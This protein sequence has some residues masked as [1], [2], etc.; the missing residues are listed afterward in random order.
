MQDT[1][2][3]ADENPLEDPLDPG[4][5]GADLANAEDAA[6]TEII[7]EE[8]VE[9]WEP[10]PSGNGDCAEMAVAEG[11]WHAFE[12]DSIRQGG[13]ACSVDYDRSVMG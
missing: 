4:L 6:D 13:F 8:S 11:G 7:E 1:E 10:T 5:P 3:A 12:C 2:P 9:I